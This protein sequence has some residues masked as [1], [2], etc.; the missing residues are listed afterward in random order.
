MFSYRRH[1]HRVASVSV[2]GFHYFD[3]TASCFLLT[4]AQAKFRQYA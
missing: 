2:G 3:S 1:H 4:K